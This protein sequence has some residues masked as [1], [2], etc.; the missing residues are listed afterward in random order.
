MMRTVT[1]STLMLALGM[2]LWCLS[3]V[4][5]RP[6]PALTPN[7][8]QVVTNTKRYFDYENK[9]MRGV[10]LGG[11]L[12]L[13][14]YITPSLFEP[15]RKN[16]DNDDGIPV[17]EYNLCKT[18]GREKAHERL[19]KHWSTFYTEKDFHAM[20]AAGLN[21]VRVPIGYWA[22]ELLEDDPYAQGQEEYLDKAIEWSRAAG[23]KVWVDLHGAP[24]SQN[25]FDN[26]GRRDQIEFLKPHNLELL[27]KVLEH[28]LGKYSQDEFADVVIGVEVLNEPLGPAVDIQGV[29]DLYYYAYDLMRNKFKRDQVVVIHDAFMPSQFWNSDLTL[30]KGYWG[31]VVDHHHYQVFSPG[32]LARSMDD[33]VKTAC[34]WGHDVISESHWPVCGEWSAALDDC[35]KWLNGVGVGARWDGTFNKNGDKAPYQGDCHQFYESWP[36]EKKKNTRRY[37]EAQ[38]DAYELRGGWIFW[39]W[40]TETLTEWDFQRLLAHGLMP[41]P[42]EDRKYPNQCP[43]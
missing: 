39:C 41:Q 16:P 33:K 42:L 31:V 28:T 27:H 24:G 2:A 22:F 36:E 4:A 12:V 1:S 37:I 3:G 17:D 8:I 40:K 11:W 35:A 43:F 20:K 25:G 15:F 23:L 14:P 7:S 19:S 38:L 6:L 13:E 21:I 9:T 29:R 18:L 10:N 30:D 26:S 32:E 5:A 34:A